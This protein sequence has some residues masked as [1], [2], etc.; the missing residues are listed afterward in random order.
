MAALVPDIPQVEA[1]I[2]QMTNN[3]RAEHKLQRVARN[4]RLDNAARYFARYLAR[5][6]KFAH[7]ADGRQPADRAAAK[8]YKFCQIAENLALHLDSR[9]FRS[10]QLAGKAVT[11]WKNSPGHRRN[12]L[13]ANVT[14][15]GVAV[16]KAPGKPQYISVQLF[17]R[18]QRLQYS[19]KISNY[20]K[21][22]VSY[23]D[24]TSKYQIEPLQRIV[25]TD[26]FPVTLRFH[27]AVDENRRSYQLRSSVKPRRND[28]YA[29][30]DAGR[31]KDGKLHRTSSKDQVISIKRDTTGL[32]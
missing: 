6:G 2:I 29:L 7:E 31:G 30:H 20:S 32:R 24:G 13:L 9:G 25:H 17:G 15:I 19:Y 16:A 1:A 26:C 27:T 21:L 22:Q 11:G 18:P 12:M 23:T 28:S 3:F 4:P 8:G 5:T 14:E 10:R